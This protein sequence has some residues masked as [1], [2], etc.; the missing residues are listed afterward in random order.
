MPTFASG[1]VV[2]VLSE[3]DGL[4]RVTVQ[5]HA[6]REP[7]RAYVLTDITGPVA[8]G[9]A[10]VVNTTAVELGLGTGGW[11]FVHWNLARTERRAPGPGHIMKL[12]YTGSQLDTGSAEEEHP[13]LLDA[14]SIDGMPVVVAGL[15]SQV[16]A[17]AIAVRDALPEARIAYVMTDGAA[18][19]IAFSD[20]VDALRTRGIIDTTVTTGHAFGGDLETVSVPAALTAARVAAAADVTIVAMGPGIVGTGSRLGFTG[21][22]VG[23][24]LDTAGALGGRGIAALRVSFADPRPRHR[25]LSHHSATALRLG[26]GRRATIAVPE[27]PPDDAVVLAADLAAAGLGALHELVSVAA[28]DIVARFADHGLRVT[29]MGRAAA[30][31]PALFLAAAAA[32]TFAAGVA[33]SG[34]GSGA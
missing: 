26:C 4:Q 6:E 8:V 32:G 25:G 5:L 33:R 18:L 24:I 3:R 23:P 22:E 30:A 13:A 34:G 17:V 27:L 10:V 29:S 15:H 1:P 16:P 11:H 2:A 9:D 14:T 28:P 19:P 12:R 7:E 21:M 20:L 31:D